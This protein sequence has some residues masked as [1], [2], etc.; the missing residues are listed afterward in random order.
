MK[1]EIKVGL[2]AG[3]IG[4]VVNI[5]VA[6]LL[7]ICGPVVSLLTGAGAGFFASRM[8]PPG[9]KGDGAKRG[10]TAGA[11]AGAFVLVGQLI[12][13]I[14][15][16]V[17]YQ[18]GILPSSIGQIPATSNTAASLMYYVG[19]IGTGL[20]FGIVGIALGALAGAGTGALGIKAP[21]PWDSAIDGSIKD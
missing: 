19:G 5:F 7:G 2:I 3:A 12:G 21:T 1:A 10:A 18:F 8:P 15:V 11:I 20:C 14:I 17:L 13:G 6:A 4:L 16:L 9:S